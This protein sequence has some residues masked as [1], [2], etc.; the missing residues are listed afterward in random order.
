MEK[1]CERFLFN[2]KTLGDEKDEVYAQIE[3][4][5]TGVGIDKRCIQLK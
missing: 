2:K 4:R 5:S 3:D 1:D